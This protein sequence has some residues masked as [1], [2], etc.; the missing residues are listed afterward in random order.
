MAMVNDR[1][2]RAAGDLGVEVV[3]LMPALEPSLET[4]YDF[5][6]LTP[7]GARIVAATI[8]DALTRPARA[9][10]EDV[11]SCADLRAS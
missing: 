6:H 7:A 11:P 9:L 4:Y 2:A 1:A 10:T 3:D 8:A 5:F